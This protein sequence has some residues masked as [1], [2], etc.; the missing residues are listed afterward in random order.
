MAAPRSEP[1]FRWEGTFYSEVAQSFFYSDT[2]LTEPAEIDPAAVP[3]LPIDEVNFREFHFALARAG[4]E[5]AEELNP[6]TGAIVRL[7]APTDPFGPPD[8]PQGLVY[9]VGV[10]GQGTVADVFISSPDWKIY[11]Y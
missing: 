10:V 6:A 4:Y 9:Y 11:P 8:L 7:N 2:R 1:A 3:V 5:E